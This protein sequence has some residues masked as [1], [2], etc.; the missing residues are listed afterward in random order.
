M[1]E[2]QR[3]CR[4]L[5]VAAL[6]VNVKSL[7]SEARIIRGEVKRE[8][9]RFARDMLR[10][11]RVGVL[12]KAARTAQLALAAVRGQNY[13]KVERSARRE[14]DWKSIEEK[15]K[16]HCLHPA[17]KMDGIAWIEEARKA[18]AETQAA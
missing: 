5:A 3:N 11:H 6:R 16:R 13:R 4:R 2:F 18:F 17:H 15:I 12:R 14:P 8:R 10:E 1:D 7:A 9:N